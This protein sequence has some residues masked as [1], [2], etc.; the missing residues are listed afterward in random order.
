[1]SRFNK[2]FSLFLILI[3]TIISCSAKNHIGLKANGYV[4]STEPDVESISL[5][6][7]AY[8]ELQK[9][10]DEE[11][12][13]SLIQ[14]NWIENEELKTIHFEVNPNSEKE[15]CILLTTQKLTITI[16]NKNNATW[17]VSQLVEALSKVDDR[18]DASNLPPS[19]IDFTTNCANF[20]FSY[21][22]PHFVDNLIP[23]NSLIL[24]N[25][26]VDLDW[27]I[28]GHNLAKVMK[29][30][31][32]TNIYA[33]VNNVRN[34]DQFSFGSPELFSY[35]VQYILNIFGDGE[36]KGYH[37]MIM[38]QDNNLVC[39]CDECKEM[40]NTVKNATPAVSNFISKMANQFPK[41]QFFTSSYITTRTLPK[42]KMNDNTGVFLSTIQ[43]K[44]GVDLHLNQPKTANF[45]SEL[46]S[47][48]VLTPKIYI[49]DYSANF[50]D[51]LTPI[52]TLYSLQKQLK[53][54]KSQGVEGVFINGSGYDYA[55]FGDLKTFVAGAL[56]KNTNENIDQLCTSFFKKYYPKNH[57]LLTDY[58]LSLEK[59]FAQKNKTYSLYDGIDDVL[60]TYL[61][62]ND[63]LKF[64]GA[65]E[66]AIVHSSNDE[67]EKLTKL[68]TALSYTKLQIAYNKVS[69]GNGCADIAGNELIIKPEMNQLVDKLAN[70]VNYSN[71]NSYKEA[72]GDLDT[73]INI[74]RNEILNK[75]FENLILNENIKI[76]SVPDEGSKNPKYLIDGLP[77]FSMDYHQGWYIS[78]KDLKVQVSTEKIEG[79]KNMQFRFL[80]NKRHGFYPPEKIEV[81]GD[82]KLITTIDN[83]ENEMALEAVEFNLTLD[84]SNVKNIEL[85]F[86]LEPHKKSKIALDEIRILN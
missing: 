71:L 43:L 40:G 11:D 27:G 22:D 58:Y 13:I 68:Y 3:M 37:F 12:I 81:W 86:S 48:N 60:S 15:Y 53:F 20:D 46:K 52:P 23:G 19:T 50:D 42:E 63:F 66:N 79:L 80:N 7:L 2:Y 21:R 17:I 25:N 38:P 32:D 31:S 30:I 45:V 82:N 34:K 4:I 10:T 54:Y 69:G 41:H 67:K 65:L 29:E 77:G 16:K 47:W 51:Y 62:P 75:R 72:N 44:K 84:L 26:N 59:S 5:S 49:W 6:N 74:W 35:L 33:L 8:N 73:Y 85:L 78:S 55:A 64:Y 9:H 57:Q 83:I 28:W 61:N 56:L 1:M 14:E 39:M 18:F 76:L 24:G 36:E 70:Y